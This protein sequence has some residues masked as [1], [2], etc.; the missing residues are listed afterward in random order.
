MAGSD[1][2]F[3]E[4]GEHGGVLFDG[5][6]DRRRL[7]KHASWIGRLKGP[8][9]EIGLVLIALGAIAFAAKGL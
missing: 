8:C 4:D 5:L 2:I 3:I 1:G 9:P 6:R 7:E